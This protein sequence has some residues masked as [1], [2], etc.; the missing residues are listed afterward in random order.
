MVVFD[1]RLCWLNR[2]GVGGIKTWKE[3]E[4]HRQKGAAGRHRKERERDNVRRERES[5]RERD[6]QTETESLF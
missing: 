4:K 6:R 1:L 3:T 2:K 5:E